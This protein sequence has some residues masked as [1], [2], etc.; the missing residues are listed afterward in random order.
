M[1]RF[2]LLM[3]QTF[4]P[5]FTFS[6][7]QKNLVGFKGNA[8]HKIVAYW[9]SLSIS[10]R[11]YGQKWKQWN[12]IKHRYFYWFFIAR[13]IVAFSSHSGPASTSAS[14]KCTSHSRVD[15]N[16][17]ADNTS[18]IAPFISVHVDTPPSD[19]GLISGDSYYTSKGD[20][21]YISWTSTCD[22]EYFRWFGLLIWQLWP[23]TFLSSASPTV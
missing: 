11:L 16:N 15:F 12:G 7:D 22:I 19:I 17:S 18:A 2:L 13:G 14:A 1:G 20:H 5:S 3:L 4:S 8:M 23:V 10:I 6:A 9:P 21:G